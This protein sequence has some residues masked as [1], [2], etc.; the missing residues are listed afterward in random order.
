MTTD[1]Q[2]IISTTDNNCGN[3]KLSP[4]HA[5]NL[6]KIANCKIGEIKLDNYP[7]LLIFPRDLNQFGDKIYDNTICEL[8]ENDTN[9][10]T[11]NI[12]GF[13]GVNDIKLRIKSRFDKDNDNDYF[14]H[15]MLQKVFSIN[16]FDLKY[17][18]DTE[19]IFDFLLYLFPYYLRKALQQGL[20]KEY[21]T[22]HYNDANLRG[23]IDFSRHIRQ[24]I[25]FAGKIAYRTR[26]YAYDNA[27]T[28]LVRHTIEYIR[29][30]AFAGKILQNNQET[31][32]CVLQ[33]IAATASYNRAER[34]KIIHK[35]LKPLQ[36]PY[37]SN[38][39]G[40]QRL[41]LQILRH[42]EIKYGQKRDEIYGVLFDGAWL[43]EEYLFT[44]LKGSGFKHPQNKIGKDGI[45]LFE[46]TNLI[47]AET[48]ETHSRCRRY[49]DFYKDNFIIDAK[50]KHLDGGKID[51]DDMH[52]IISYMHVEQAENGGFIFPSKVTQKNPLGTL[53]GYGG[54][55]NLYGVNIPQKA[56][57]FKNFCQ[58]M[59]TEEDKISSLITDKTK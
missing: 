22:R 18:S 2:N 16:L 3:C 21:Q 39:V 28:Q 31:Q 56:D 29:G 35:N 14:L 37:F 53:H 26:E 43:W 17:A 23:V 40:L 19:T 38:Y 55:V 27:V 57:C 6:Q 13:V 47:D 49:P 7:N 11:G 52:Q 15:Y 36:Q 33:I 9:L 48:F 54:N 5:T 42:Q 12:M 24:H 1:S 20:Y 51:R 30:H 8:T 45:Y 25:P 50:Y 46:K 41:C 59:H 44:V 34:Q 58:Q 4:E 10:K 32:A